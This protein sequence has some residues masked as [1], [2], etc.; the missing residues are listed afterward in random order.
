MAIKKNGARVLT[1]PEIKVTVAG[2]EYVLEPTLDAVRAIC[3]QAE[4]LVPAFRGV[5]N[6]NIDIMASVILA[7]SGTQLKDSE[8]LEDFLDAIW[9]EPD[10]AVLGGP[11]SDY[12][13]LL[14]AGG[15]PAPGDASGETDPR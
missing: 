1:A 2:K 12:I 9:R 14:L 6:V 10:K 8:A 15:S 13:A 4:G 5:R 3:S 7:G 11:L